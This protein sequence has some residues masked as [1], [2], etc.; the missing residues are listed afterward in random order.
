MKPLLR[1]LAAL[2]FCFFLV[3]CGGQDPILRYDLTDSI[4]ALDPQFA[5]GSQAQMLIRHLFQGLYRQL[6]NGE[7]EPCLAESV[8]VSPDGLVYTFQIR[9]DSVWT[10]SASPSEN[11]SWAQNDP[12]TAHD[13]EFALK[14]LFDPTA[15]S[16]FASDFSIIQGASQILAGQAGQEALGVRAL[17]DYTLEITL[18]H[19]DSRLPNLLASTAAMP[20]QQAFFLDTK[21]Q[22]GF[23]VRY[24]RTNG[25]FRL[26]LWDNTVITIRRSPNYA[27]EPALPLGV[28]FILGSANDPE[29]DPV[30]RFLAGETDAC[31]IEYSVKGQVEAMGGTVS[32]FAP[33]TVWVLALNQ[34]I[35]GLEDTQI[36]QSLAQ[37][38]DRS[39]FTGHLPE[40]LQT[41]SLLIPPAVYLN[42]TSFRELSS[43]ENP[44]VFSPQEARQNYADSLTRLGLSKVPL[45]ELLICDQSSFALLA[46]MVQQG[47]QKYLALP[48][49]L[50]RLTE[51]ELWERVSSGEYQAALLPLSASSISP[52]SILSY[53]SS[54]SSLNFTGY[55]NPSFD[56]LLREGGGDAS[57]PDPYLEAE[58]LLLEEAV[59][60]P[61]FFETS[62]YGMAPGVSGVEFSPFSSSISFLHATKE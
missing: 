25:P 12:V 28:N 24:L 46:G 5:T 17:D 30:A 41:T 33:D 56:Q 49:G 3:S 54:G 60:I 20:C 19:P 31:P 39:L 59:V 18:E 48:T 50:V 2:F 23:S 15:F 44:L 37:T 14:R 34:T 38:V 47:W 51:E 57:S 43:W 10:G 32:T 4:S 58:R 55:Q 62:Y 29:F 13:F 36:R 22:Y 45:T 21:G 61:L 53:F 26:S 7:V 8:E 6:P 42:G 1:L 35:P 16:P 27:G 9:Q 52:D 11:A 40:H